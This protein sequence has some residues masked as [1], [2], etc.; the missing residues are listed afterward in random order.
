MSQQ[1]N[2][3]NPI[4]LKQKRYFSAATM[5]QALGLVLGGMLVFY[6]YT[7]YQSGVQARV[8]ADA[9]RQL[10]AQTQQVAAL[11]RDYSPQGRS[12]QL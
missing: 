3:F 10:A 8:A 1:I 2:L 11:T 4:F 9:A 5:L 6:G 12:R 7:A